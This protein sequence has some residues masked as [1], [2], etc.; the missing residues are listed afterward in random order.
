MKEPEKKYQILAG[1]L[2]EVSKAVIGKDDIKELL[3]IAPVE[4]RVSPPTTTFW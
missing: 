1:I 3:L 4:V 2:A